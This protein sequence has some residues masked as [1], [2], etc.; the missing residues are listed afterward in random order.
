M[1]NRLH[2]KDKFV[3]ILTGTMDSSGMRFWYTSTPR[4]HDTGIM[5]VGY[6]VSPFMVIPPNAPNF[7]VTGFMD[8]QCTQKVNMI[9]GIFLRCNRYYS[10]CLLFKFRL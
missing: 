9:V 5:T 3:H 4:E 1:S 10:I 8:S 7:T 6:D 2:D